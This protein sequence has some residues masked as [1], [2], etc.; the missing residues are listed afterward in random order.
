MNN[1]AHTANFF[2]IDIIVYPGFKALEAIGPLKVFDCANSCLEQRQLQGGYHVS[3]ASTKIGTVPSDTI[4][5]LQATK[6]LDAL[7]IPDM[8]I[9][10]GAHEIETALVNSP[11]IALWVTAVADKIKRLLA[12]YNGVFFWL[13]VA[14]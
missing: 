3:I 5:S 13:K 10:V 12:L 11:E 9:I 4:M 1:A 2:N 8:A 7:A 14:H 6:K